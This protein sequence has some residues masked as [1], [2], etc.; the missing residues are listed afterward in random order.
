MKDG[1]FAEVDA[2]VS[3]ESCG[4]PSLPTHGGACLLFSIQFYVDR[5]TL[6]QALASSSPSIP[7]LLAF[8]LLQYEIVVFDDALAC[9]E[10]STTQTEPAV[11]RLCHGKS[12]LFEVDPDELAQELQRDVE[13]PLTLLVLAKEHG[14]ARL[15]AFAAVPLHLD[16]GLLDEDELRGSRLLRIC[17]WASHSG[18]WELRDH[19]NVAVGSVTGAVTLSC[20]G[21]ALAPHL[22]QAL[23][24]QVNK[25]QQ[26]SSFVEKEKPSTTENE[27]ENELKENHTTATDTNREK[28]D[29]VDIEVEVQDSSVQCDE[30]ML[31]GDAAES[32]SALLSLRNSSNEGGGTGNGELAK[33]KTKNSCIDQYTLY[34]KRSSASKDAMN[35]RRI[36]HRCRSSNS[37][38]S[39][40]VDTFKGELLFPRELPP[41][42]FFKKGAKS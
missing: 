41:P 24:V 5:V 15:R 13:T 23:G 31:V 32:N 22:T 4:S 39:I 11:T 18:T 20:L 7:L 30:E 9:Q 16:I 1:D 6:N 26:A 25:S 2:M 29:K 42:L 34:Y 35:P 27:D 21:K 40:P 33:T 14:R 38:R 36:V 19:H 37:Q 28:V 8:Q 10:V 12:C 17:E 3:V